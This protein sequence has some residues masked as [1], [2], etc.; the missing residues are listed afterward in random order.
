MEKD[1]SA[2]CSYP[3]LRGVMKM[4]DAIE[5]STTEKVRADIR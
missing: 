5:K 1:F 3:E 4:I 2:L